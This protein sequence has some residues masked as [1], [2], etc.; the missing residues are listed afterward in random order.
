M[1]HACALKEGIFTTL[2][3]RETIPHFIGWSMPKSIVY[4]ANMLAQR[5]IRNVQNLLYLSSDLI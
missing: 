1:T 3:K 4:Y 5:E 2:Q